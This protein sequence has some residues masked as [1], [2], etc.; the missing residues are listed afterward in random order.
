MITRGRGFFKMGCSIRMTT[1]SWR[2]CG[3]TGEIMCG[4]IFMLGGL[5]P[6][7]LWPGPGGLWFA[8]E[9]QHPQVPAFPEEDI[10]LDDGAVVVGEG[11][12]E[13]LPPGLQVAELCRQPGIFR[14]RPDRFPNGPVTGTELLLI[15][16]FQI[17]H[18]TNI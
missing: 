16:F 4:M 6:S 9:F 3:W 15:D 5:G 1:K 12:Q 14:I 7:F 2:N 18:P 10:L 13:L 8:G 11:S 17:N